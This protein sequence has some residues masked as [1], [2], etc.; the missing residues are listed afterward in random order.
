MYSKYR[1]L[2]RGRDRPGSTL[3]RTF[4]AEERVDVRD[5]TTRVTEQVRAHELS[6]YRHTLV[7]DGMEYQI[8][9]L[10]RQ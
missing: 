2:L 4:D 1:L 5:L 6:P 10:I 8:V 7:L 3:L 9:N